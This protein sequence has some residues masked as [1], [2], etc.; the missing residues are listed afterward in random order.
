LSIIHRIKINVITDVILLYEKQLSFRSVTS[1]SK[2]INHPSPIVD[3]T[4]R[5][6]IY[7]DAS[8]DQL[9]AKNAKI[10]LGKWVLVITEELK[11]KT[12]S[13]PISCNRLELGRISWIKIEKLIPIFEKVPLY[14]LKINGSTKTL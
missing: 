9:G 7:V 8:Y 4:N 12:S 14:P 2:T 3:N 11:G 13:D 10:R 1:N 5:I 6:A